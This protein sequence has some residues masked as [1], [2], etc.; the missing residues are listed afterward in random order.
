MPAQFNRLTFLSEQ[1][2]SVPGF[3]IQLLDDEC[4]KITRSGWRECF[5]VG[6]KSARVRFRI[7]E[8]NGLEGGFPSCST[9]FNA[10]HVS[11]GKNRYEKHHLT[12]SVGS[13]AIGALG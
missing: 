9:G 8:I 5:S 13:F 4:V 2:P 1:N 10:W 3:D 11:C 7:I 6:S 12:T